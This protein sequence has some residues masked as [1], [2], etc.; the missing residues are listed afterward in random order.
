M[1]ANVRSDERGFQRRGAWETLQSRFG[2]IVEP[3]RFERRC[4]KVEFLE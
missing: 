1:F 3:M 4:R 2:F